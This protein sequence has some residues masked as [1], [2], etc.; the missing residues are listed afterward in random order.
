MYRE[1]THLETVWIAAGGTGNVVV[2]ERCGCLVIEKKA[3]TAF[4]IGEGSDG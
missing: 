3:H 2:C 1:L 4:H